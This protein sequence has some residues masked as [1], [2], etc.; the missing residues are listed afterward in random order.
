MKLILLECFVALAVTAAFLVTNHAP[1]AVDKPAGAK[2][3]VFGAGCFWGVEAAFA[4]ER[5]VVATRVGYAG[6]TVENPSYEQVCAGNTGH[7]EVVEVTYDPNKTSYRHLLAVFFA[8]HDP[9]LREKTQYRSVIFYNSEAQ[10]QAA[11]AAIARLP[12][13]PPILTA[14]EPA[15]PFYQAEEYHQHYFAKHNIKVC[16]DGE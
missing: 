1:A 10:R 9:T 15:A 12:K 11:R 5:G 2:L 13:T 4:A 16:S 7:T 3:A 6:G 14:V 8:H